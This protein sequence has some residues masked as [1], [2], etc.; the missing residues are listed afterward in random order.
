M[1][2]YVIFIKD[3]AGKPIACSRVKSECTAFT[4]IIFVATV[5]HI[6]GVDVQRIYAHVEPLGELD[7][8]LPTVC[9]VSADIVET[10]LIE[11]WRVTSIL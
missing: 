6:F 10:R 5:L 9:G 2:R 1:K 7:A 3:Q 4:R 11:V 8:Y